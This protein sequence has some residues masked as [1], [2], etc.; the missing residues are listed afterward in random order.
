MAKNKKPTA[1]QKKV[2]DTFKKAVKKYKAYKKEHPNGE[3]KIKDF[4]K[5]EFK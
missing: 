4:V 5:A 3:K 2:Q 1:K